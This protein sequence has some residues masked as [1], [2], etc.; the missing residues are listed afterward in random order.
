MLAGGRAE[1]EG[2]REA[3]GK[4]GT[5]GGN[6]RRQCAGRSGGRGGERGKGKDELETE[7]TEVK[8]L[9]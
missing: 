5:E 6:G 9:R 8:R 4:W 2:V 3:K 7:G 1:R